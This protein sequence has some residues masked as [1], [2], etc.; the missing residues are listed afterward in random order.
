[1]T[2]SHYAWTT[3]GPRQKLLTQDRRCSVHDY[4]FNLEKPVNPVIAITSRGKQLIE[5][6]APQHVAD[7]RSAVIDQLTA[8]E[9]ATLT[10]IADK[11]R[12]R[13][14]E[15]RRLDEPSVGAL[16]DNC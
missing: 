13:L 14:K 3:L 16:Q 15:L 5:A 7:V 2:D 4:T 1:M 11:V 8:P 12:E 10:A 9:L 6:A